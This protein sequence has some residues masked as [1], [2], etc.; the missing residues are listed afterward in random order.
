MFGTWL[1]I[2]YTFLSYCFV[3]VFI[4]ESKAHLCLCFVKME[5]AIIFEVC[6]VKMFGFSVLSSH[7]TI[8]T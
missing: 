1:P 7:L 6:D 8:V 5:L 3:I 2:S 4:F